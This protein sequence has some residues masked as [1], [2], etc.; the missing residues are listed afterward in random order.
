MLIGDHMNY[1]QRPCVKNIGHF[2]IQLAQI[3]ITKS[4]K[5]QLGILLENKFII[6]TNL[7]SVKVKIASK[8]CFPSIMAYGNL[9]Y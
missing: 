7:A 3:G 8:R 6:Q 4:G 2:R 1:G 9:S 5:L